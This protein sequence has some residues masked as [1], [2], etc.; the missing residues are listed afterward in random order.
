[1]IGS[2]KNYT[3]SVYAHI[4]NF[5]KNLKNL[6]I[7][8]PT[9]MSYPGLSLYD[10]PSVTFSSPT[11]AHL[12]INVNTFDDCL[13]LLDGRVK[14]LITLSITVYSIDNSSATVLNMVSFYK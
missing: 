10:L 9:V 11:L 12:C 14:Q 6:S 1:M 5:F 3:T 7:I 8:E 13:Y 4:L 2:L